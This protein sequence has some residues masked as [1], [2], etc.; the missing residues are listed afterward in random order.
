MLKNRLYKCE[1]PE[2][3]IEVSI[4]STIKTGEHKGKKT[5]PGCKHKVEGKKVVRKGLKPFTTKTREKRK[6]ERA[7]LPMFFENA[8][9]DLEEKP[10]CQ[11]CGHKIN[12]RYEPV[13]N[14]AHILPKSRYKSVMA[15]PQNFIFLCS[16]KDR[17][18]GK[19][20]HN[21]FDSRILDIPKMACFKEAKRKFEYFKDEVVER[22]KIFTIFEEND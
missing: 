13:R 12:T 20:C 6:A 2:C 18:D 16:S 17:D 21:R 22:G 9:I 11:N 14:I 10:T 4:R 8:I 1:I 3:E 19:D 7:R 5:C 15:H